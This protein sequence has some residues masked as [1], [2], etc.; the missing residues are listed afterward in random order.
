MKRAT[1]KDVA[2]LAG[3]SQTTV[4][5]V[6]NNTPGVSLS[7]ETKKKVLEAAKELHY[8]PNS[9]GKGL[10]TSQSKLLGI[11]LPSLNNPFYPMVMQYI[12]NHTAKLNYNV[13]LCCT[14]R[15][16]EREKTYLDL[17]IEKQVDGII[18]L[19]TPNWLKRVTQISHSIPVLLLSEKSDDIPLNTISLNGFQCGRLLAEHLLALGHREIAYAVSPVTSVSLTRSMRLEGIKSAIKAAGLPPSAL[20]IL[21]TPSLPDLSSEADV[22]YHLMRQV[23]SDPKITAVIGVND[24]VAFGL[25]SYALNTP[26]VKVPQ[27]IS[28]CGFDNT[29]LSGLSHPRLTTVDYCTEALCRLAVD[30]VLNN[31]TD[32]S[33]LKLAGEP[34]LIVRESTGPARQ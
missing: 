15:N 30:M 31:S 26:G 19:F 20:H 24:L 7:E 5:F 32:S 1:S 33:I 23:L 10:R 28:I 4:S 12:E 14:Y 6:M 29:F 9:F 22:G 25:L 18:Y 21:D 34:Q 11:F 2:K 8:I 13:M 16:S 3:V 27:D 17:C